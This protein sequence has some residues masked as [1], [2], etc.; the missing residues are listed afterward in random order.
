LVLLRRQAGFEAS[1]EMS[2]GALLQD[3]AR[4]E[5]GECAEGDGGEGEDYGHLGLREEETAAHGWIN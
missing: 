3:V 2:E 5:D 4:E 1:L